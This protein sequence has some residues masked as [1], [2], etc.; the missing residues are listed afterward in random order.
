LFANL[1]AVRQRPAGSEGSWALIAAAMLAL[2]PAPAVAAE[3]HVDDFA[4]SG[5]S[6][7]GGSGPTFVPTGG[8]GGAG[9]GFLQI[10]STGANLATHTEQPSWVGDYSALTAGTGSLRL[11]A[12]FRNATNSAPL[13][14][15]VVLFGPGSTT[16]RWTSSEAV[17]VPPDDQWRSYQFELAEAALT[18]VLGSASYDALMSDVVRV[19]LRHDPT[20]PS[21]GGAGVAAMLGI[22]NVAL[23]RSTAIIPEPATYLVGGQALLLLVT[24]VRPGHR[25][26]WA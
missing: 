21:A 16:S 13:E 10:A 24:T 8:P 6:W 11:T 20:S 25:R 7:A 26:R 19:M 15:R 4:I 22:D 17:V 5:Q 12:D 18:R 3:I 23:V 1:E 9:D 14:M 2:G